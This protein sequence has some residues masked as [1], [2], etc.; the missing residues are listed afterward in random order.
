MQTPSFLQPAP[1]AAAAATKTKEDLEKKE[2]PLVHLMARVETT[3]ERLALLEM[4][5][6]KDRKRE[7]EARRRMAPTGAGGPGQDAQKDLRLPQVPQGNKTRIYPIDQ[8]IK[9]QQQTVDVG[10]GQLP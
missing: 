2:D 9:Q 6:A 10:Q 1:M 3:L 4:E 8:L 5:E 7:A